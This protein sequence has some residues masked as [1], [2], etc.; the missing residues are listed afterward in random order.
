MDGIILLIQHRRNPQSMV[1]RAR[2]I[3]EGLKV[4]IIGV[5]L[6]QVPSGAGEDY[7]Y[8][9]GNYNYYGGS[10]GKRRRNKSNSSR[11]SPEKERLDLIEPEEPREKN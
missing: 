4:P 9:T 11:I 3:I 1:M 5:V 6:N 10:R 7:A 2:Q 8:Y